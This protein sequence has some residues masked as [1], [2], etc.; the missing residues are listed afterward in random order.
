[1]VEMALREV[2]HEP[3]R[4]IKMIN[5]K[6]GNAHDELSANESTLQQLGLKTG[7]MIGALLQ[8]EDGSW[9]QW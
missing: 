1:M 8:N 7:W 3:D 4:A 6:T 5:L 9:P 2:L